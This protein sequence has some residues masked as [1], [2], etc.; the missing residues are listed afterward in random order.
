MAY[1]EMYGKGHMYKMRRGINTAQ[2]QIF[3]GDL[4]RLVDELGIYILQEVMC[5]ENPSPNGGEYLG[6]FELRNAL[7]NLVAVYPISEAKRLCPVGKGFPA[8]EVP[9]EPNEA[10]A[11]LKYKRKEDEKWGR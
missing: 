6:R 3:I 4:V 11:L 1:R 5:E 2:G 10:F 9:R 8:R 7:T